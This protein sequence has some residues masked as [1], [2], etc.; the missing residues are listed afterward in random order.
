MDGAEIAVFSGGGFGWFAEQAACWKGRQLTGRS[1][2]AQVGAD[3]R[4]LGKVKGKREKLGELSPFTDEWHPGR[5]PR[6]P[7]PDALS[8]ASSP[9]SDRGA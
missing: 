3:S 9:R 1:E 4:E 5:R 7:V 2:K 8:D 6:D